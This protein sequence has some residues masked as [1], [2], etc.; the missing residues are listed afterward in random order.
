M[1]A[2]YDDYEPPI[3]YSEVAPENISI[4]EAMS[5][6][7]ADDDLALKLHDLHVGGF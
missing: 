7:G 5:M 6:F 4:S 2:V 1:G 3:D